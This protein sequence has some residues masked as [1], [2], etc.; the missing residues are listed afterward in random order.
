M[1]DEARAVNNRMGLKNAAKGGGR[2]R[3]VPDQGTGVHAVAG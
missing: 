3:V 2:N 1:A